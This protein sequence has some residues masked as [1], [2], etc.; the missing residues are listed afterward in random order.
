MTIR[1][2][3]D[4]HKGPVKVDTAA[5][6]VVYV[7]IDGTVAD[8]E[9]RRVYVQSTPRN[10]GAFNALMDRDTPKQ[11][12]IDH[13]KAFYSAGWTV[14][15]CS[16]RSDDNRIVTEDWLETY[17]VPYH[18]LFMRKS[19]LVDALGEPIL[20]RRG[21]IQPD[22]RRDDIIKEEI[23]DANIALG[24]EPTL[25]LDDRDQVVTM[26][27]KRGYMCVQVAEGDF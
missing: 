25:I 16:G 17:G 5:G 15:M 9:H 3:T 11:D 10:W 12:I 4:V 18:H 21:K 8:I 24:L 22:S 6:G 26:W 23:L 20:S 19:V 27:R 2:I 1:T 14:V 7:D 13:V